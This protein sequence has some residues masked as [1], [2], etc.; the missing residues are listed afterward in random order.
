MPQVDFQIMS[1]LHLETPLARPA[2]SEFPARI[3]PQRPYLA[4]LGDIGYACDNGLFEFLED[5]L[6]H[7]Q[8]VFF[9]L[10]NHEA[11]GTSFPA[12]KGLVEAFAVRMD[13]MR[14]L[15]NNIGTFVFSIK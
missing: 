3:T 13:E 11:Y 15:S 9:L 8:I 4:L 14:R 1:D 10:G 12:A 5:Q 2:Y 6:H 7:F